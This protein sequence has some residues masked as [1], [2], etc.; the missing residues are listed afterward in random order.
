MDEKDEGDGPFWTVM[1]AITRLM[2]SLRFSLYSLLRS[3]LSSKFSPFRGG[4]RKVDI[5][6]SKVQSVGVV[7]GRGQQ[8]LDEI[9][10][11]ACACR[12]T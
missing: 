9:N 6:L 12:V 1:L 11:G 7:C 2:A 8:S 4:A 3:A 5:L 10:G